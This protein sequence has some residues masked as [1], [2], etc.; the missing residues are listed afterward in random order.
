MSHAVVSKLM[1][2]ESKGVCTRR[3]LLRG[4]AMLSSPSP[5]ASRTRRERVIR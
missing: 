5:A 2:E 4:R 3:D 1:G